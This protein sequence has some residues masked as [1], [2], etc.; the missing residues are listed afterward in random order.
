[1]S[2]SALMQGEAITVAPRR[3]QNPEEDTPDPCVN[4]ETIHK[5]FTVTASL[6]LK[7]VTGF[8]I[9]NV[10]IFSRVSINTCF[11]PDVK[12][13]E[14]VPSR[15]F[16]VVWTNLRTSARVGFD[17]PVDSIPNLTFGRGLFGDE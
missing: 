11:L 15:E 6:P 8:T 2:S 9:A 4:T 16:S 1:M 12:N 3:P 5:N 13:G 10:S 17:P 7:T 14:R